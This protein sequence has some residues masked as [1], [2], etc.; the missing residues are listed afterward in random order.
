M[1]NEY[2]EYHRGHGYYSLIVPVISDRFSKI[3]ILVE[4]YSGDKAVDL[5]KNS[6]EDNLK[7]KCSDK[8]EI[9]D[10]FELSSK[11]ENK[12]VA[13]HDYLLVNIGKEASFLTT[14]HF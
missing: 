12:G 1:K 5:A 7:I 13:L 14:M 6:I 3:K 9:I 2:P 8:V 11:L 4:S 10:C